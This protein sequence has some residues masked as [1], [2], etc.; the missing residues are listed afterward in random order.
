MDKLR[1]ISTVFA[2]SASLLLAAQA[3]G[4]PFVE[5]CGTVLEEYKSLVERLM[6]SALSTQSAPLAIRYA[7]AGFTEAGVAITRDKD[8][9]YLVRAVFDRSL[10][11]DSWV[12]VENVPEDVD[13]SNVDAVAT[14]IYR[15]DGGPLGHEIQDFTL[16]KPRVSILSIPVSDS[17]AN[18]LSQLLDGFDPASSPEKNDEILT[19]GVL[20]DL[21]Q[22]NGRC[23]SI[24]PGLDRHSAATKFMQLVRYLENEMGA[25]QASSK[26]TFESQVSSMISDIRASQ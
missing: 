17:F 6:R 19:D 18:E 5:P 7:T 21:F 11:Y 24:S 4:T 8:G 9:F 12:D 3:R 14:V 23:L 20:M 26:E 13:L 10:W 22:T 25:W 16:V 1:R 2:L 15:E